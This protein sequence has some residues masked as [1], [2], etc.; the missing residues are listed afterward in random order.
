MNTL[1]SVQQYGLTVKMWTFMIDKKK[2]SPTLREFFVFCQR[3]NSTFAIRTSRHTDQKLQKSMSY[4]PRQRKHGHTTRYI[5]HLAES[6]IFEVSTFNKH[7][8]GLI[9][10]RFEMPNCKWEITM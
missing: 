1:N 4:R 8:N 5:K 9:G 7:C 2:I 10:N 3:T 6:I